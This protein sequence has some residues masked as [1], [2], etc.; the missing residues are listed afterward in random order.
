M[1]SGKNYIQMFGIQTPIIKEGDDIVRILEISLEETCVVPVEG[2]IFVLAESAVGTAEKRVIELASIVPGEKAQ[3][4]GKK[5]GIDPRE[6]ELV[7]KEC[8]EILGGVPELYL[9]LQKVFWPQM[10]E[11]MH[12]MLLKGVSSCSQRTHKKVRDISENG[13]NS[14]ILVGLELLSGTAELSPSDL[15]AQE[16][17]L[18]FQDFYL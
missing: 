14:V 15:D 12:P 16:L 4:L 2:D 18:E 7:T 3:I 10:Q 17:R 13:L 9:Q 1:N 5:Y 11:S 6:M 8:D